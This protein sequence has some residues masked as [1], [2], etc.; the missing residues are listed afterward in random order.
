MWNQRITHMR[1]PMI[2]LLLLLLTSCVKTEIWQKVEAQ[3]DTMV[4]R[5]AVRDTIIR[6][7]PDTTRVPIGWNPSVNDWSETDVEM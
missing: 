3:T 6:I 7:E 2:L 4:R 1:K 5:K